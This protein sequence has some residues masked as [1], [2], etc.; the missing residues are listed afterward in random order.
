MFKRVGKQDG[1][2]VSI[3]KEH[4][5]KETDLTDAQVYAEDPPDA[6]DR[7][8]ILTGTA[9]YIIVTEFCERLTYYGKIVAE[10]LHKLQ[11][12]NHNLFVL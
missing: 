8:S 5:E 7:K 4:K 1:D 3:G 2:D 9:G 10:S 12:L 11:S 6:A